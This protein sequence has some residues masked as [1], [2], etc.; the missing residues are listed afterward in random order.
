M[1][2]FDDLPTLPESGNLS[3]DDLIGVVDLSDRRSPKKVS[4]SQLSDLI[5]VTADP[6]PIATDLD[7]RLSSPSVGEVVNIY[8]EGS[9]IEQ[10]LGNLLNPSK[11]FASGAPVFNFDTGGDSQYDDLDLNGYCY[12]SGS[13]VIQTNA[14]YG[15]NSSISYFE[16]ESG[17][18]EW[19]LASGEDPVLY[20]STDVCEHVSQ[21]TNWIPNPVYPELPDAPAFTAWDNSGFTFSITIFPGYSNPY[22]TLGGIYNGRNTYQDDSIN[23]GCSY[24]SDGSEGAGWYFNADIYQYYSPSNTTYPWQAEDWVFIGASEDDPEV[25]VVITRAPAANNDNW[26]VLENTVALT[27]ENSLGISCT[28]NGVSCPNT[29][30]TYVGFVDPHAITTAGAT[31]YVTGFATAG[32]D[33]AFAFTNPEDANLAIPIALAPRASVT[34]YLYD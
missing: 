34:I 30:A 22:A 32:F 8:G 19:K 9:R 3:L 10:F 12:D 31:L 25:T 13:G 27:V 24:D 23:W 20:T 18:W 16:G 15:P 29:E 2:T 4:L 26:V 28:V 17:A 21:V 7:K 1:A 33:G 5:N 14:T 6:T 11:F